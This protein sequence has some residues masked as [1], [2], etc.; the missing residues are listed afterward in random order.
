MD[1]LRVSRRGAIPCFFQLF[2]CWH[3]L[4]DGYIMPISVFVV[5]LLSPL[6]LVVYP[7]DSLTPRGHAGLRSG[8]RRGA[9]ADLLRE[10]VPR[11][12]CPALS[13]PAPVHPPSLQ[14]LDPAGIEP[15]SPAL[16]ADSLLSELPGKPKNTGVGSLFLLQWISPTQ[17]LNQDLLHCR[18]GR[19][20]LVGCSPWGR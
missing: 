15:R 4:A 12:S 7:S 10:L 18:H 13:S 2:G 17:E 11:Q 3:S 5:T 19:R 1:S 14:T 9:P 20:S 6:Q 16:Q 8:P